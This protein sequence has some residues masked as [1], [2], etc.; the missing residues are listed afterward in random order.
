V[1]A[2]RGVTVNSPHPRP[3][4]VPRYRADPDYYS[5]KDPRRP[6][7]LARIEAQRRI[8][9]RIDAAAGDGSYSVVVGKADMV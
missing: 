6:A 9:A 4:P 3:S 8:N 2:R 1:R 7:H 5:L